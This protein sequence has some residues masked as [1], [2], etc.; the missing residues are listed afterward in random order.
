MDELISL[1]LCI[2]LVA[3]AAALAC[4]RRRCHRL[5]R[6]LADAEARRIE[7]AGL[8]A[9]EHQTNYRMACQLYGKA[10]VVRAVKKAHDRGVS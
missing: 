1:I 2:P 5:A 8:L 7:W 3:M 10:A 9:L 6:E 4:F